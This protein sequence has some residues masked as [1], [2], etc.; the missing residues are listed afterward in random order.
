MFDDGTPAADPIPAPADAP[1]DE[2]SAKGED[3]ALRA[4]RAA[5]L[6][7][8]QQPEPTARSISDAAT[9]AA[10]LVNSARDAGV[11]LRAQCMLS[12]D[13]EAVASAAGA[14]VTT[15][16]R[17]GRG[18]PARLTCH[19]SWFSSLPVCG[20][21]DPPF[22]ERS[23]VRCGSLRSHTSLKRLTRAFIFASF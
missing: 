6:L 8:V 20:A 4:A 18:V 17:E 11:K 13:A 3:E 9:S 23:V 5:A 19:R 21:V 7:A 15:A 16:L 10:K 1:V 2:Q 22:F 12:G 14:A